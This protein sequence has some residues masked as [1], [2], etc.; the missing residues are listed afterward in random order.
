MS[1][2]AVS[3]W[4]DILFSIVLSL[5]NENISAKDN[6]GGHWIV[7]SVSLGL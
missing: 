1:D 2:S 6:I 3:T 4:S 5:L 7:Q